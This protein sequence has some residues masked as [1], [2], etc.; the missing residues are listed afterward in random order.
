MN[1]N[2]IVQTLYDGLEDEALKEL[3]G[4]EK[5]KLIGL[6][7]TFGQFI[8]NTY[9]LWSVPWTPVVKNG[10]DYAED[11]PDAISMRIIHKLHEKLNDNEDPTNITRK[12]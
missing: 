1:E 5:D 7:H 6:H 9:K 11:H 3:K 8:R 4:M 10:V 12:I 2:E